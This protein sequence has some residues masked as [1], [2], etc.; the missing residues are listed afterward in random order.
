MSVT[1]LC[2]MSMK[3]T[4]KRPDF[5]QPSPKMAG[6]I[7][8]GGSALLLAMGGD[9]TWF[10]KG[11]MN[12]LYRDSETMLHCNPKIGIVNKMARGNHQLL[13]T[14]N[15]TARPQQEDLGEMLAMSHRSPRQ[16]IFSPFSFVVCL[17]SCILRSVLI[18]VRLKI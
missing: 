11:N 5:P 8:A 2:S 6:A 7:W 15:P 4:S 14:L 13:Q 10:Q 1:D 16:D 9:K 17:P 3:L 12:S 18:M